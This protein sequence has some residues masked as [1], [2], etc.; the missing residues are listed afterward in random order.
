ML[1]SNVDFIKGRAKFSLNPRHQAVLMQHN[2]DVDDVFNS[3]EGLQ[4]D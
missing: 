1:K 4:N 3:L 2:I